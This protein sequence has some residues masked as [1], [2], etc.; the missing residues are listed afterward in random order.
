MRVQW[1]DNIGRYPISFHASSS[2]ST[3]KEMWQIINTKMNTLGACDCYWRLGCM[4][5]AGRVTDRFGSELREDETKRY[6]QAWW[7]WALI[8]HLLCLPPA[9][10]LEVTGERDTTTNTVEVHIRDLLN[11]G[12]WIIMNKGEIMIIINRL[13]GGGR[14]NENAFH[15]PP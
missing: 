7:K 1:G 13:E 2:R 4:D 9:V 8:C 10:G 15:S 14:V 3:G 11:G 6:W 5:G 12:V